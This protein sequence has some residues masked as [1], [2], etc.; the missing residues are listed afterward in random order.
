MQDNKQ[1][2][3]SENNKTTVF[4]FKPSGSHFTETLSDKYPVSRPIQGVYFPGFPT[5]EKRRRKKNAPN[6]SSPSPNVRRDKLSRSGNPLTLT[7]FVSQQ[8]LGFEVREVVHWMRVEILCK[9]EVVSRPGLRWQLHSCKKRENH[10]FEIKL[11]ILES[12]TKSLF[13]PGLSSC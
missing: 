4:H 11:K 9:T 10:R 3:A 8:N 13:G 2:R 6:Q 12:T 5:L 7:F 1:F